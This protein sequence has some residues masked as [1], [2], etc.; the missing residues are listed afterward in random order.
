MSQ[1]TGTIGIGIDGS[2]AS[3]GSLDWAIHQALLERRPL[4]LLH[5][6]AL[7]VATSAGSNMPSLK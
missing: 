1:P 4:T 3:N 5:A 7:E 6:F 2:S